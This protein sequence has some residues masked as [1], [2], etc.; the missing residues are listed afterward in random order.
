MTNKNNILKHPPTAPTKSVQ[1]D[2]FSLF[3]SNDRNKVSNTIPR[4]ENIP[5]YFPPGAVTTCFSKDGLAR[6]FEHEWQENNNDGWTNK[7]QQNLCKVVIQPAL[8][9]Q[10]DGN[11]RAFFPGASEEL[12]EEVLKKALSDQNYGF[13]DPKELETWVRFTLNMIRSELKK[14]HRTRSNREVKHSIQV[15]S[16]CNIEYFI[17][18]QEI[19]NGSI[20]QDLVTVGRKEYLE[21]TNAHHMAR[22]PVFISHSINYLAYR[23]FNYERLMGC[24]EQLTRWIYKRMINHYKQA[25]YT[26]SYHFQYSSIRRSGLLQQTT[27]R[28]NRKKVISSLNE[29]VAQGVASGYEHKERKDG[30]KIIDV[31]YEIYP[32]MDFVSEQKAANKRVK[33]NHQKALN[34][35]VSVVDN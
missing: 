29:L 9:K 25:N 15:M 4:W 19:W 8:I 7:G 31:V 12:I 26:N 1:Y 22:L 30:R 28:D 6:P 16:K 5:K 21:D 24:K 18:G 32:S 17:N 13:H 20:L 3:V 10:E 33:D 27:E 2:L 23:Q 34:E 11:Y 14:Q 35:G